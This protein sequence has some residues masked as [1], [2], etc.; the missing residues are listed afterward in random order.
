M[1]K[2][3]AWVAD[4]VE[5]SFL[6]SWLVDGLISYAIQYR[7]L[8]VSQQVNML[9]RSI[10]DIIF[11]ERLREKLVRFVLI[12]LHHTPLYPPLLVMSG[13]KPLLLAG[14]QSTRMGRRKEL[15]RLPDGTPM[16]VHIISLLCEALPE[17]DCVYLSLRNRSALQDL[18][19]PEMVHRAS[20]DLLIIDSVHGK[21][22]VQVL[23]DEDVPGYHT[24]GEIGPA[25][26]LLSA[27]KHDPK[28]SWLVV[29]CDYPLLSVTA[30]DQLRQ[31][32]AGA[33]ACFRN[34]D[35]YSEPLLG[36]WSPVALER[37]Q[38]NV[39]E[40]ITG[41]SFVVRQLDGVLVEPDS[42]DWLVNTNTADEW[43]RVF[44]KNGYTNNA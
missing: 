7:F 12:D 43:E 38:R 20:E 31:R 11:D 39:Q 21:V 40:G 25:S 17:S 33:V 30:I 41:P 18:F 22:S 3:S 26:G 5:T 28:S 42:D 2:D 32:S 44:S 34:K 23:Y 15:L 1:S 13:I 9:I 10:N 29:A 19:Q 14:G 27:Y 16:F 36:I 37:L 4:F 24:H 8:Q 6:D 35:G